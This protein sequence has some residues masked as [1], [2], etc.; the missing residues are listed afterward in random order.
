MGVESIQEIY[1]AATAPATARPSAA[2]FP[3]PRLAIKATMLRRAL[4]KIASKNVITA[5]PY[6]KKMQKLN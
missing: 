2:D 4:S 3:R 5:L 1:P 6:K